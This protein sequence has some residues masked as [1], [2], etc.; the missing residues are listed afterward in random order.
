[1]GPAQKARP[2]RP[3][4]PRS[5]SA[6]PIRTRPQTGQPAG[7]A[8]PPRGCQP[9]VPRSL[10]GWRSPHLAQRAHPSR[11]VPPGPNSPT[12]HKSPLSTTPVRTP[13]TRF[14]ARPT[15]SRGHWSRLAKAS[16]RARAG[17]SRRAPR[18]RR[19]LRPSASAKRGADRRLAHAPSTTLTS[20]PQPLAHARVSQAAPPPRPI[21]MAPPPSHVRRHVQLLLLEPHRSSPDSRS[22]PS[23]PEP[24]TLSTSLNLFHH[25]TRQT[26]MNHSSRRRTR[27][28]L[29]V[30]GGTGSPRRPYWHWSHSGL[31]RPSYAIRRSPRS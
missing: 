7:P 29:A 24:H 9:Q 20:R 13:P 21:S 18:P 8:A 26:C 3:A 5:G 6:T 11:L 2:R 28:Q 17:V 1:M 23:R 27:F 31:D 22:R 10:R 25:S 14:S 30:L 4:Q 15:A 16:A 19:L 12:L